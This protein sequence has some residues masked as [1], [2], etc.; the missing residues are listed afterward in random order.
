MSSNTLIIGGTG[1][2]G[3]ETVRRMS[4]QGRQFRVLV[5]SEE[6]ART[7]PQG[8]EPVMGE[9]EDASSLE[10]AMR[11]VE[12]LFLITPLSPT[13]QQ[14]GETAVKAAVKA[15]VRQVVYMSV[16]RVE[17]IPEAP[18]FASKIKIQKAIQDSGLAYTFLMPNNFYQNDLW[19]RQVILDFGIYPQPIGDIGINRVDVRDI[20][21]AA[22]NALCETGHERKAYPL[23]GPYALT[24]TQVAEIWSHHLGRWIKYG[25]NDLEAWAAQAR[26]AL[27]DWLVDDFKIMYA[28]FQK[29]GL[30][31]SKDDMRQQEQILHHAPRRFGDF[32]TEAIREWQRE[33]A[34]SHK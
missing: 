24:G 23:V 26:K 7:L 30:L 9:L 16:H 10:S 3:S 14:Q 28:A 15:G 20:A 31:A 4:Q 34:V 17:S 18:H 29:Q 33:P 19:F 12:K 25:G 11:G 32:V 6:K 2:V 8:A 27:P 1:T 21:E 13:E 5:R 22:V